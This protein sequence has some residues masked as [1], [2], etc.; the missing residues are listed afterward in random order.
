MTFIKVLQKLLKQDK[1]D[2][3]NAFDWMAVDWMLSFSVTSSSIIFWLAITF[4]VSWSNVWW[5]FLQTSSLQ[6]T[7]DWQ[8]LISCP[9][10]KQFQHNFMLQQPFSYQLNILTGTLGKMV[11]HVLL[12]ITNSTVTWTVWLQIVNSCNLLSSPWL[13]L[14][15]LLNGYNICYCSHSRL[16]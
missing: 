14:V 11:I 6:V 10:A 12:N 2:H 5:R 7:F 13:R 9:F 3:L 1:T 16:L 8:C 15:T 4:F